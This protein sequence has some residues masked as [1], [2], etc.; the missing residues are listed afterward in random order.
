MMKL[1]KDDLLKYLNHGL[2]FGKKYAAF[3]FIVT[4]LGIYVYQVN[5][6]GHLIE[7]EPP[8][9][10]VDDKLKPVS[11]LKID[12]NSIKQITDLESHNIEVKTLFDQARQNPFTE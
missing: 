2:S 11:Q 12:E 8:Q 7:D 1:S 10:A 5:H 6:I 4:F 3:L 9:S